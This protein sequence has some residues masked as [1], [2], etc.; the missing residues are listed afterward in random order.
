MQQGS[1]SELTTR[2]RQV[3]ALISRGSSNREIAG[4]LGITEQGVKSH[5]SRLLAR[6]GVPNRTALVA[7]TRSW[8]AADAA[9][10]DAMDSVMSSVRHAVANGTKDGTGAT[11]GHANGH[12]N[13]ASNGKKPTVARRAVSVEMLH[14][15][16]AELSPD[17]P[18]EVKLAVDRLRDIVRELNVALELASDLPPGESSKILVKA[19]G[20]RTADAEKQLAVLQAA[21][22]AARS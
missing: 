22:A 6:H 5:V 10:Y 1:V 8:S 13:G 11:N 18:A 12:G 15:Q 20:T 21:I 9:V 3:L 7:A 19:V 4:E 17:A 2:Q 16:S 14:R